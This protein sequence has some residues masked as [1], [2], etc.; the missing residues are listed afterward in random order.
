MIP[1]DLL[2]PEQLDTAVDTQ[3]CGTVFLVGRTPHTSVC[4]LLGAQGGMSFGANP[5]RGQTAFGQI[6][7]LA[8]ITPLFL[9]MAVCGDTSKEAQLGI[10]FQ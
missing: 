7:I 8:E 3:L 10:R 9:V 2:Y 1:R 5:W 6:N 4:S